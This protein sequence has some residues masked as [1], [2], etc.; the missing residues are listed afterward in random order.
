MGSAFGL[1]GDADSSE[2]SV[3]C[4]GPFP[5]ATSERPFVFLKLKSGFDHLRDGLTALI[6]R[7]ILT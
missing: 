2:V 5:I 7:L 6:G 1:Q 3:L 4:Q